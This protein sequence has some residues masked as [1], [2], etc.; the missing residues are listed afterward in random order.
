MAQGLALRPVLVDRVFGGIFHQA[1]RVVHLVHDLV[2]DIGA[3]AAANALVLQAFAD[4][5]AGGAHLHAQAAVHAGAQAGLRQIELFGACAP[6]LAALGV[7]GDDERVF[8]KH[9]AL[10]AGIRAHVLADLLAHKAGVAVG[11][12]AIEEHPKRLPGANVEGEELVRELSNRGE[13]T[14]KSKAGPHAHGQP[15]GV[16]G[17]FSSQL[18][19]GKACGVAAHVRRAVT[20]GALFYPQKDFGVNG[21][22]AGV[23]APQAPGHGRKQKQRQR[24]DHQQ[25]GEVDEVL[26]VQH[27]VKNVKAPRTQVKQHRLALAPVQPRQT[28]KHQLR[29]EHGGP[30]DPRKKTHHAARIDLLVRFVKRDQL[31]AGALGRRDRAGV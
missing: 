21:L 15:D 26:R 10:K 27:Q 19:P 22:R 28:V 14:H 23:A 24:R 13:I 3:G 11:G 31:R 6:G 16:L 4:V 29:E 5:D 2:A 7:V 18:F 12:K 9:G 30:T 1:A 25:T 8:V 20:L 17:G